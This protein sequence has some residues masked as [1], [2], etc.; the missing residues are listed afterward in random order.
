MMLAVLEAGAAWLPLDPSLPKKR[1]N[2]LVEGAK[3]KFVLAP[4]ALAGHA[5]GR[6]ISI[7]VDAPL[8]SP[9]GSRGEAPAYV[10]WTS[11]ST[12]KPKGVVIPNRSLAN[13]AVAIMGRYELGPGDRVLHFA[14]LAFDVAIEEIVPT[15]LAGATVVVRPPG[16]VSTIA[17]F[18]ALLREQRVTVVNLPASYWHEWIAQMDR[19]QVEVPPHLRLVVVGSE[20]L[21]PA[22]LSA[23]IQNVGSRVRLLNAYGTT[24]TA[25]TSTIYDASVSAGRDVLDVAIGKPLQGVRVY[26]VDSQMQL[27]PVGVPGE[28]LIGDA[29]VALGYLDQ[30][31]ETADRFIPDPFHESP[32]ARCYRT[33]DRMRW[34][35]DGNLEFLGRLDEQVK[36][37]GFR[38]E[39][40]E[41]E[42]ALRHH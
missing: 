3:P 5:P 21:L 34:R 29:S 41:V 32:G 9:A 15:L 24:E 2:A 10:M 37:R 8:A 28:A 31:A 22:S 33:G 20:R 42:A 11:G 39:P 7:E 35:P 16:D 6:A 17:E 23:W 36:I 25:I 30:P 38:V 27:L 1:L 4:S 12:G 13:H 26:V 18:N 40:A 14:S 19:D